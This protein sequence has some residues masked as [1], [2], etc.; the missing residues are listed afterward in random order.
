MK[1]GA[2]GSLPAREALAGKPSG[3]QRRVASGTASWDSVALR[4]A[5]TG[6]IMSFWSNFGYADSDAVFDDE[7]SKKARR[8]MVDRQLRRRN[9]TNERVLAA[10]ERVPRERFLPKDLWRHA[11]EDHPLP[12]GENQTLS[13]P[14]IVALMTELA[15]PAPE[16]R[17]LEVGLGSGYQSAILAELCREVRGLEI[18][19][20]L[21][22]T[23]EERLAALGYANIVVRWGDGY[24]GWPEQTAP[25]D[26]I[27][28]TAAPDHVPSPLLDQLALGGRMVIP[29]G[30]DSQELFLLEKQP[31]GRL[32]QTPIIPVQFVPMTG[33]AQNPNAPEP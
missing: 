33:E 6:A 18:S 19:E 20:H 3:A 22:A 2:A 27:L 5:E 24:R 7:A 4:N 15:R 23:A 12:I 8:A 29:I 1:L 13:Q 14:Y 11:Y 32:R 31:D 21:A 28:V 17:A 30:C 26:I 9:I 25:F 10:M 16:D